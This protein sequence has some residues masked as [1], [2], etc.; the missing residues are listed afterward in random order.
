MKVKPLGDRVLVKMVEMETKTAG[1]STFPRPPRRRP[2][3]ASSLL[4]ATTRPSR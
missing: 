2:R 1:V 4:S 3:K